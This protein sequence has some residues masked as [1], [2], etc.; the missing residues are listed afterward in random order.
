MRER[1]MHDRGVAHRLAALG[2]QH[3]PQNPSLPA[4]RGAE[5]LASPP[6]F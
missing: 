6:R 4:A 1:R 2:E 5:P 3:P